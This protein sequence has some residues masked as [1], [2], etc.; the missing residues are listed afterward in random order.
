MELGIIG[1]WIVIIIIAL[2][3]I[4]VLCGKGDFLIAGYNTMSST[5][6]KR[7]DIK[8]IRIIIGIGLLVIAGFAGL[9]NH[10][11][12]FPSGGVPVF[13]ILICLII[14]TLGIAIAHRKKK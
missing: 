8:K 6:Q 1:T 4:L 3:G 13:I 7:Y 9:E 10:N 5:E 2:M 12:A 14:A 11:T